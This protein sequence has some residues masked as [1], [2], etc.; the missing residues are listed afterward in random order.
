MPIGANTNIHDVIRSVYTVR[1]YDT[2][3]DIVH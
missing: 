2:L 3:G 1:R